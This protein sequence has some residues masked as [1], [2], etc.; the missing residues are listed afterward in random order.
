[1]LDLSRKQQRELGILP[2]QV[3]GR[4]RSLKTDGQIDKDMSARE[5][6]FVVMM[7]A[8]ADNEYT[9]QWTSVRQGTY[10]VDWEAIADFLERIVELLMIILP[11]FI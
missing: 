1:M 2:R 7:D 4:I 10:G 3:L 9:D 5:I 6:A 11:L 8:M